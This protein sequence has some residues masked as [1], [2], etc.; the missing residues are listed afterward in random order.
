MSGNRA[1][2]RKA[3]DKLLAID[4]EY[5]SRIG[6]KGGDTPHI[7]PGGFGSDVV[8]KDGLTGKQRAKIARWGNK[9]NEDVVTR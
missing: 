8:G 7:I 4:P 9:E 2:A 6:K 5:Y 3:R 1:G